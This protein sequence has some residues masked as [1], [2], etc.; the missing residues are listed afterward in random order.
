MSY[1]FNQVELTPGVKPLIL[2][3][4]DGTILHFPDCD[5]FCKELIKE[6]NRFILGVSMLEKIRE[7]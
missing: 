6:T 5:N 4:I 3:D 2:C 1:S 7:M